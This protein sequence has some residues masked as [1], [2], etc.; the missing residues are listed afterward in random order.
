MTESAKWFRENGE[1][2]L[3]LNMNCKPPNGMAVSEVPARDG[4]HNWERCKE[5]AGKTVN[6]ALRTRVTT[7]TGEKGKYGKTDL[8]WDLRHARLYIHNPAPPMPPPQNTAATNN[9][10]PAQLQRLKR[11]RVRLHLHYTMLLNHIAKLVVH[12]CD[13]ASY[14]AAKTASDT[15]GEIHRL[16]E[17]VIMHDWYGTGKLVD[18]IDLI[19][20]NDEGGVMQ[21]CKRSNLPE[22]DGKQ[23]MRCTRSLVPTGI[24]LLDRPD[25][26]RT[27]HEICETDRALDEPYDE[28]VGAYR[29]HMLQ[30]LRNKSNHYP[31]NPLDVTIMNMP[32][33]NT[34]HDR[35][36]YNSLCHRVVDAAAECYCH[37]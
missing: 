20:E 31:Y 2:T 18:L 37:Q 28:V 26:P 19:D 8:R 17:D 5:V 13:A 32:E 9:T 4:H 34:E 22:E 1:R 35:D 16:C 14:T 12:K 7:K 10:T 6:Q 24:D 23:L 21:L 36:A 3:Y 11:C 15:L 29:R 25:D 27:L 30:R 33:F